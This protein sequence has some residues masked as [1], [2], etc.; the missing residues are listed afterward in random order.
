WSASSKPQPWIN[1]FTN[2][3]SAQSDAAFQDRPGE[4]RTGDLLASVRA[5]WR[6]LPALRV[7]SAVFSG[8]ARRARF[9]G[10]PDRGDACDSAD[11]ARAADADHRLCRGSAGHSGNA[12]LLRLNDGSLL[13]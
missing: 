12:R 11:S 1:I 7:A 10:F 4:D 5:E 9:D 2:E 6:A 8:L 13:C 3:F